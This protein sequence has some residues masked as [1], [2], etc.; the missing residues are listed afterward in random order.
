M[1]I[2]TLRSLTITKDLDGVLAICVA[3][4]ICLGFWVTDAHTVSCLFILEFNFTTVK[5]SIW[6]ALMNQFVIIL[7]LLSKRKR[8][9][10]CFNL[11]TV[12]QIIW[13]LVSTFLSSGLQRTH[14]VTSFLP[15]GFIAQFVV[16]CTGITEVMGLNPVQA[17][18]PPQFKFIFYNILTSLGTD[19]YKTISNTFKFLL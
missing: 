10:S 7:T 11:S 14:K 1:N 12:V 17:C 15:V 13:C 5:Q 4:K 2:F 9:L 8:G 6:Q 3:K 16:H 19:C 18:F